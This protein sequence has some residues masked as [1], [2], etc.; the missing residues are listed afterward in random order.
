MTGEHTSVI[1]GTP[2]PYRL[3]VGCLPLE[4]TAEELGTFFSQYGNVVEA[5]VVLNENGVSK[6][7]GFVTF[8]NKD[9]V[10]DLIKNRTVEFQKKWI[11]VGPAVK[12]NLENQ[13]SVGVGGGDNPS[14]PRSATSVT[15]VTKKSPPTTTM[16]QQQ[17]HGNTKQS[18]YRGPQ[19]IPK[20]VIRKSPTEQHFEPD[21]MRALTNANSY[22]HQHNQ[23]SEFC[24]RYHQKI[25]DSFSSTWGISNKKTSYWSQ[26]PKRQMQSNGSSRSSSVDAMETAFKAPLLPFEEDASQSQFM[27]K[28]DFSSFDF[29]F[30]NNPWSRLGGCGPIAPPPGFPQHSNW[31]QKK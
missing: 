6:R 2:Y 16:A 10:T 20:T 15:V 29:S 7:F 22:Q 1:Y 5:K 28:I 3:F 26:P 18:F 25:D 24:P 27:P 11:N 31:I 23:H 14:K 30:D 19:H 12:K 17:Q 4:A 9:D 8:T 13:T 21:F